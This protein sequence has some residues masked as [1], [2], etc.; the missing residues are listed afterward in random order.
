[1]FK[2]PYGYSIRYNHSIERYYVVLHYRYLPG[3]WLDIDCGHSWWR[4]FGGMYDTFRHKDR[5]SDA[6]KKWFETP[7]IGGVIFFEEASGGVD[8]IQA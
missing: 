1:M 3:V 4:Q 2:K 7:P 8:D 6:A 5:A